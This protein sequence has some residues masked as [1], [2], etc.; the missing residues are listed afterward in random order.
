MAAQQHGWTEKRFEI[1]IGQLLRIGV[2]L[3]AAIVFAG[4][5][6]YLFQHPGSAPSFHVFHGEPENLRHVSGI[7]DFAIR[8]HSRGFIQL[9][10]LILIATP[11][12]RV[13]F[14]V[15]GF[16]GERDGLYVGVTLTVLA[17]LLYSFAFS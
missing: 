12:A 3:S 10:L 5:V 13:A 16:A 11:V 7:V 17:L 2:M 14:S 1:L 6:H 15:V 4:G 8:L 9:G